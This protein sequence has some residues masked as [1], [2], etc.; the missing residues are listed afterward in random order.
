VLNS[1]C[2]I[3]IG[4]ILKQKSNNHYVTLV[5]CQLQRGG[6]VVI[7][8]GIG[9]AFEQ[10]AHP[11]SVAPIGTQ[12]QWLEDFVPSVPQEDVESIILTASALQKTH[13]QSC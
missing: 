10:K 8:V 2:C 11:F 3:N 7:Y 13:C 9:A 1:A 4:A 6:N 5:G 12:T